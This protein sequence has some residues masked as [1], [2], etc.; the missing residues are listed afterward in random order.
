MAAEKIAKELDFA[1]GSPS[2]Y[3]EGVKIHF[4]D[5]D[6]T[7]TEKSSIKLINGKWV[8]QN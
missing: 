3:A 5:G 4:R 6:I 1:N 7:T 2:S 8:K